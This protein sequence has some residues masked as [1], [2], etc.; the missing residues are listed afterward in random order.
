MPPL[1]TCAPA[2]LRHQPGV[3]PDFPPPTRVGGGSV[4]KVGVPHLLS[5]SA[6]PPPTTAENKNNFAYQTT[7]W[8]GP[9]KLHSQV[10]PESLLKD[11]A[12]LGVMFKL[13]SI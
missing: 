13:V 7:I 3:T 10:D 12:S 11:V 6:V 8:P 9:P 5:S 4:G 1:L 2:Q